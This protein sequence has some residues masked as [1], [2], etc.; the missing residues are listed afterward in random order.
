M[1]DFVQKNQMVQMFGHTPVFLNVVTPIL[2][3]VGQY[4]TIF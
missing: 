4:A 2:I 3:M 1:L